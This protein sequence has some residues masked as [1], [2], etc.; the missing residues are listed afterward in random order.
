[1]LYGTVDHD[2]RGYTETAI[3]DSLG[4]RR[5][6]VTGWLLKAKSGHGVK[7][8]K[9]GRRLGM[10]RRLTPSQEERIYRRIVDKTADQLC[11]R[12]Q[13][14][15]RIINSLI[16]DTR[17]SRMALPSSG[18]VRSLSTSRAEMFFMDLKI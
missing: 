10:G 8:S 2:E 1:M 3:A 16:L 12:V 13:G 15:L 11:D 7:E 6:T 18:P 14:Y 5:P 4:I 17:F 9:R